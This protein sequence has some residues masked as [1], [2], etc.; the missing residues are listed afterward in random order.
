[1]SIIQIDDHNVCKKLG[2]DCKVE[3]PKMSEIEHFLTGLGKPINMAPELDRLLKFGYETSVIGMFKEIGDN[4]EQL[5][6]LLAYLVTA[7]QVGIFL[8]PHI[9]EYF[10][11]FNDD[12]RKLLGLSVEK[13]DGDV[14]I[15][16]DIAQISAQ[17]YA[18]K[19][20]NGNYEDC[21]DVVAT[22]IAAVG[23]AVIAGSSGDVT[24]G[25][26][27][28]TAMTA[29]AAPLARMTCRRVYPEN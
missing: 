27:A 21:C 18:E 25:M 26:A 10:H 11:G 17:A 22:S 9:N 6:T 8:N 3:P 28:A 24:L 4:K 14:G 5:Y 2:L 20:D 7:N 1:M 16:H 19:E 15:I 29:S 23:G 13:D 12:I